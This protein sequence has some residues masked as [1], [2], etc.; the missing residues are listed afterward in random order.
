[1]MLVTLA[2]LF[3]GLSALLMFAWPMLLATPGTRIRALRSTQVQFLAGTFATLMI[4]ASLAPFLVMALISGGEQ[5]Q[6][7]AQDF[8]NLSFGG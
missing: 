5:V 2:I 8:Q 1:M 3:A 7:F 6:V 4:G